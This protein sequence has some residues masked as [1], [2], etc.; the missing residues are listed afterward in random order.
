MLLKYR[1]CQASI[2]RGVYLSAKSSKEELECFKH[3][4]IMLGL[5]SKLL[6]LMFWEQ[7]HSVDCIID[8]C[9]I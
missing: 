4:I 5:Q 7:L 2:K 9:P 1:F 8:C 6:S 3:S